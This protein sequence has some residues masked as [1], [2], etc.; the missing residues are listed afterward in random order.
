MCLH[1]RAS[2]CRDR[3]I[4]VQIQWALGWD[5]W[6]SIWG[7]KWHFLSISEDGDPGD[8]FNVDVGGPRAKMLHPTWGEGKLCITNPGNHACNCYLGWLKTQVG[9][10]KNIRPLKLLFQTKVT[11]HYSVLGIALSEMP[12]MYRK[13]LACAMHTDGLSPAVEDLSDCCVARSRES[14][15]L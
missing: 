1:N 10:R 2:M 4:G 7:G 9:V 6:Q 8:I 14:L 12:L 5:A 11:G 13:K 15:R 3:N